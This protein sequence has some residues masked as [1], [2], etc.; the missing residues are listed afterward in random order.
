MINDID[1]GLGR[2]G[3]LQFD[4]DSF[5]LTLTAKSELLKDVVNR[6]SIC[7][8]SIS[9]AAVL[10]LLSFD[11]NLQCGIYEQRSNHDYFVVFSDQD[12]LLL[13]IQEILK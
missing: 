12:I 4:F 8:L 9:L 13:F 6:I 3:E 1:A 2:F 11:S 7:S 5:S 10:A